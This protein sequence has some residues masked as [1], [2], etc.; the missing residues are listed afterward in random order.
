LI[1]ESLKPG[2]NLVKGKE[3]R[4]VE[5]QKRAVRRNGLTDSGNPIFLDFSGKGMNASIYF[6]VDFCAELKENG[7]VTCRQNPGPI[8]HPL[9]APWG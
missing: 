4:V 3:K 9:I 1:R 5:N 6:R 8:F 7:T 2:R